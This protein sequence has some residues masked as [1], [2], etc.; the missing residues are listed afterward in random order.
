MFIR[1]RK[2]IFNQAASTMMQFM[3]NNNMKVSFEFINLLKD[4]SVEVR[5][6]NDRL[7]LNDYKKRKRLFMIDRNFWGARITH[8]HI[9]LDCHDAFCRFYFKEIGDKLYIKAEQKNIFEKWTRIDDLEDCA[10]WISLYLQK[11]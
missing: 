3:H 2:P 10:S 11:H 8:W 7:F 1:K 9:F 4:Y 6:P 5:I